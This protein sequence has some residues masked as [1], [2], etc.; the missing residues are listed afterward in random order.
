MTSVDCTAYG[1][2]LR[3][4]AA[5]LPRTPRADLYAFLDAAHT[6]AASL[7]GALATALDTFNA[8][9]SEDGHLLLRGLP[10]EADADLPTTPSSTPAPED[11]SLLTMEAMLGLVG[12]RLGLHTGYRE[13]RSGTVYHDVYPSPGAHHL[14]SE[15]SETLLEFHTEMAYHRLQPNYVMLACSR[16]DHER[17]AATL[18]ASVRKALPLLD[19]RTRARLL[20]RRM[21]CCVD[22]AFR[23]GVDDPGAIAQVK[24]LYGDADDPFLGYDREL[25]APED[26][27]D[28]EAVAALSKALDEVTEAV[29]L[30]PGDLLI[31]D[32]FRTTH[33]R[34]PFSPRW[35]GKDRWLHRVYIRTDRNGQLSGGER[36]GD[37]VAFTPRG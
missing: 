22:V 6:A 32:N 16:A 4:L 5:R 25:L 29:Y 30:E 12:R 26:P 27:A 21:P 35:D 15:T 9:G 8:E 14:S 20:D 2:E 34:T 13:L 33:A 17:T 19:E 10:V 23:G 31:V 36:A 11:R 18:V 1:P 3:A 24:P 28:K 37:V 7:P